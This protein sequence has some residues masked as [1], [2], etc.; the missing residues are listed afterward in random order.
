MKQVL[1]NNITQ[2]LEVE[3]VIYPI[4]MTREVSAK[5]KGGLIFKICL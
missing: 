4:F 5:K 2:E 3:P 1:Q